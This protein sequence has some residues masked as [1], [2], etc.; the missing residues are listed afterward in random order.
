MSAAKATEQFNLEALAH[1]LEVTLAKFDELPA[2]EA[3]RRRLASMIEAHEETVASWSSEIARLSEAIGRMDPQDPRH[4]HAP[5]PH[6][7]HEMDVLPRMESALRLANDQIAVLKERPTPEHSHPELASVQALNTLAA[8]AGTRM[9][10]AE[11]KAEQRWEAVTRDIKHFDNRCDAVVDQ[12]SDH[13][14]TDLAGGLMRLANEMAEMQVMLQDQITA[15]VERNS[16]LESLVAGLGSQMAAMA[17]R[18]HDELEAMRL[19]VGGQDMRVGELT[20]ILGAHGS[21]DEEM[22]QRLDK[23]TTDKAD[24]VHHHLPGARDIAESGHEHHHEMVVVRQVGN[25]T[26]L[27]CDLPNCNVSWAETR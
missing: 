17:E 25:R 7:H 15:L 18:T 5:G 4:K 22:K 6:P 11:E 23:L 16:D 19:V 2:V 1:K 14:H 27:K 26:I 12:V 9:N 20:R 3:E 24:K 10:Q 21:W 13:E 8:A